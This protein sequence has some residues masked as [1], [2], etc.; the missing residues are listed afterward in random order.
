MKSKHIEE[1]PENT[2]PCISARSLQ[3]KSECG[4]TWSG[5][6][7]RCCQSFLNIDISVFKVIGH[8]KIQII[9]SFTHQQVVSKP[10]MSFFLLLNTK[11]D[12]LNNVGNQTFDGPHRL[13]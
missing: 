1:I 9:S 8:P 3:T 6:W 13:P 10:C 4:Q 2:P 12:M 11:E 5:P 7:R